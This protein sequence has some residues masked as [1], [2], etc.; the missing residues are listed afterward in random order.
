MTTIAARAILPRRVIRRAGVDG[1]AVGDVAGGVTSS[2]AGGVFSITNTSGID[3]LLVR[4]LIPRLDSAIYVP[5]GFSREFARSPDLRLQDGHSTNSVATCAHRRNP[6]RPLCSPDD[7][8]QL[9]ADS[10]AIA[11]EGG[12]LVFVV[13]GGATRRHVSVLV[14]VTLPIPGSTR[15]C[16]APLTA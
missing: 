3:A 9:L 5:T 12:E 16:D 4:A 15:A 8:D 1:R 2:A 14:G 13:R 7:N 10:I 11:T 6:A